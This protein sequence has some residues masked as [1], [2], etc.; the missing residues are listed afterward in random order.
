MRCCSRVRCCRRV[1]ANKSN[2][3]ISHHDVGNIRCE[4]RA[5]GLDVLSPG[6]LRCTI[7]QDC[8]S[9]KSGLNNLSPFKSLQCWR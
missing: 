5:D 6:S 9:A 7:I 1:K 8:F 3:G 2:R 4:Y